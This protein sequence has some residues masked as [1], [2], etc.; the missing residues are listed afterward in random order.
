MRKVGGVS[1]ILTK[2]KTAKVAEKAYGYVKGQYSQKQQASVQRVPSTPIGSAAKQQPYIQKYSMNVETKEG[3]DE[4]GMPTKAH[5]FSDMYGYNKTLT[6]K[7]MEDYNKIK[8]GAWSEDAVTFAKQMKEQGIDP[9]AV[10]L[11]NMEKA[12]TVLNAEERTAAGIPE[13]LTEGAYNVYQG[14][15]GEK[16]A[17]NLAEIEAIRAQEQDKPIGTYQEQQKAGMGEVLGF[18]ASG[19]VGAI[20]FGAIGGAAAAKAG[21]TFAHPI[22][23]AVGLG[24]VSAEY[25]LAVKN[26][27]A[28]V[29]GSIEFSNSAQSEGSTTAMNLANNPNIDRA[30]AAAFYEQNKREVFQVKNYLKQETILEK[31]NINKKAV[32][33]LNDIAIWEQNLE[34]Q[35][36]MFYQALANPDPRKIVNFQSSNV[37]VE[38]AE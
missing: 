30:K 10:E 8:K 14:L 27:S 32:A 25:A 1:K 23:W 11:Y 29:G 35:D 3:F 20:P 38:A 34:F 13:E 5:T 37:N 16:S 18:G 24:L 4:K 17:E 21:L 19:A 9:S 2:S 6:P 12:R 28:N 33:E 7:Q 36:A 22:G 15:K 31:F 26:R